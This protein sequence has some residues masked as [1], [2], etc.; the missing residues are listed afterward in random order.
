MKRFNEW[1]NTNLVA[2]CIV[3]TIFNILAVLNDYYQGYWYMSA[4]TLTCSAFTWYYCGKA[5]AYREINVLNHEHLKR[6]NIAIEKG[7]KEL[8]AARKQHDEM[9]INA[10]KVER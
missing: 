8:E 7:T 2:I 5:M 9:F 3:L 6:L 4:L 1:I 10:L